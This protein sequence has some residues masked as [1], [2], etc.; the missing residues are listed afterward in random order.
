MAKKSE[1]LIQP[2]MLKTAF[3][4]QEKK[5]QSSKLV[6]RILNRDAS[7]FGKKGKAVTDKI[8]NRLGWID[9]V[10][11]MSNQLPQIERLVAHVKDSGF[12]HVVVM[13]MGGSSLCPEVFGKVFGK[14]PWL[15]SYTIIDTTAPKH[16]EQVL[17]NSELTETFFIVASKSGS[18]IETMSQ[19]RFFFRLLKDKRPLKTGNYFAAITDEYSELHRMARRNRFVETF[20]NPEDIGG[21]YSALSF[22]GLV[23]G[24]FT[25]MSPERLLS[26]ATAFLAD[27]EENPL[28]NDALALGTI[29][30]VATLKGVDK[31]RFVASKKAAAFIPW[32]EQLVAESTGKEGKGIIPIEGDESG[33]EA[34]RGKDTLFVY[35]TMN[36]ALPAGVKRS[37]SAPYVSIN[38]ANTHDLGAEMLK[39]EMATA[40]A[41]AIMKVNPFDE[42]NVTESKE[43]TSKLLVGPRGPRKVVVPEPL[44]QFENA[45]IM[46]IE[47][48]NGVSANKSV[49]ADE[50]VS[51]F[52]T[53]VKPTDYLAFLS[54]TEMT[55]QVEKQI[56]EL[57]KIVSLKYGL[58][59]LRGYGP[60][61]LHSIGQLYK[62]GAQKGHFIFF[63]QEFETDY[64]VPMMRITFDR[65]IKAQAKGDMQA[66]RKR[67]RPLMSVSLGSDPASGIRN[68]INLIAK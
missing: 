56:A 34:N 36:D 20:C 11:T 6:S 48:V 59:C 26:E 9:V 15:Q 54:Y 68:F 51:Q 17:A 40:V 39:W 57:R 5:A 10:R 24:A 21:R 52:L 62:G 2:G 42:P 16:I 67:K 3:A 49:T 43:N 14:Q 30:G 12:K 41:S 18:T 44:C 29:M 32:I 4:E 22:F 25:K 7:V 13:G 50:V 65:L 53:N 45:S 46:S 64:E 31:L 61:Y 63:E 28:D 27:M 8:L 23:P 37:S 47:G 35:Y 55:P 33:A 1:Q 66:L 60:R 38:I 58:T 19:F